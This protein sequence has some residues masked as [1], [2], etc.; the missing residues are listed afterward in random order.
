MSILFLILT[1]AM[2]MKGSCVYDVP[3]YYG[4]FSKNYFLPDK[5][6]EG[7]LKYF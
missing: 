1:M 6:N 7:T 2:V 5:I 3:S 4:H